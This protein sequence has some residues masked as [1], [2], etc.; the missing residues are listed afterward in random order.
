MHSEQRPVSFIRGEAWASFIECS[1][2][3]QRLK[4]NH[5]AGPELPPEMASSTCPECGIEMVITRITPILFGW[6]FE[7][8]SLACKKCGLGKKLRVE[9]S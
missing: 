6:A 5:V 8:F 1:R 4:G 9:R 7:E 3:E 2:S